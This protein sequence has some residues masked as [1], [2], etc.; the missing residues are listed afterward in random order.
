MFIPRGA[1][2]Q[3]QERFRRRPVPASS[4][5]QPGGGPSAEGG[6]GFPRS[7]EPTTTGSID[8]FEAGS[9]NSLSFLLFQGFQRGQDFL[10]IGQYPWGV[11]FPEAYHP[12]LIHHQHRAIAGAAFFI[13]EVVS[14]GNFAFGMPVGQLRIG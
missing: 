8:A 7:D 9:K 10:R 13:P 2:R 5:H 1:A 4:T 6:S 11:G 12:L 14:L 3:R